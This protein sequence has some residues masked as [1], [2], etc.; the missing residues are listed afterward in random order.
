MTMQKLIILDRDGVINQDSPDYIKSPDEWI[1]IPGSLEAIAALNRAGFKVAVATNQ[2]GIGRGLYTLEML[3]KIHQKM[4]EQLALVEG[5]IDAIF[6][7]PHVPTENCL[8]RK[9][10]PGL[11]QQIFDH[12][13]FIGS[14]EAI[15]AIGDSLR[16]LEAAQAAGCSPILVLTGNGEKTKQ[17]LLASLSETPIY[18]S[19]SE[20]ISAL[21]VGKK[22]R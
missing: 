12:F 15:L 1:P 19:L 2:S 5:H 17:K 7:C 4:H 10:K 16:D 9:P 3:E 21:L 14:S 20:A 13:H 18:P 8:C 11:F 22:A 6:F